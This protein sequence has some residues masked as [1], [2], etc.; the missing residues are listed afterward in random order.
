MQN[1]CNSYCKNGEQVWIFTDVGTS[2]GGEN[3]FIQFLKD[4]DE[5]FTELDEWAYS[6]KFNRTE[7][8]TQRYS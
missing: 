6:E 8:N 5:I 4:A 3:W 1:S 7:F 2:G